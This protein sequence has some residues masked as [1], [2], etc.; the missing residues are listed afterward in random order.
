MGTFRLFHV[1]TSSVSA[2]C[3]ADETAF[4]SS[5]HLVPGQAAPFCITITTF[6]LD[7]PPATVAE[8]S[9]AFWDLDGSQSQNALTSR[10]QSHHDAPQEPIDESRAV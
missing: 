6:V 9:A 8:I 4:S 2:N 5:P 3:R 7:E 10:L 1:S